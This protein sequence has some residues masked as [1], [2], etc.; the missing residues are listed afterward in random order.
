MPPR[1]Q[2]TTEKVIKKNQE[3]VSPVES[4]DD[5]TTC[6]AILVTRSELGEEEEMK[7]GAKD[8]LEQALNGALHVEEVRDDVFVGN[9]PS[10]FTGTSSCTRR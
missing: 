2:E 6:D 4:Q 9:R 7:R 5:W 3:L 8:A 1:K 10:R